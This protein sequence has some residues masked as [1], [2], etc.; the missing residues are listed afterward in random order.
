MARQTF[1]G[2]ELKTVFTDDSFWNHKAEEEA[3][4]LEDDTYTVNGEAVDSDAFFGTYGAH[5]ET[6]PD[7]AKVQVEGY[8]AWQGRTDRPADARSDNL[9]KSMRQWLKTRSERT[10]VAT[11][12]VATNLP[13]ADLAR[14]VEA[15]QALGGVM[16]G[17]TATERQGLATSSARKP[18]G[19]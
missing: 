17:L 6:L 15:V 13:A 8:L 2:A 3:Y 4:Y 1:T 7:N 19:T 12:N 11:F 14:L 10:L 5:L 16:E 9:A 18:K